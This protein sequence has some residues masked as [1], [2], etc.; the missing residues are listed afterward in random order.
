M[1]VFN[2]SAYLEE[3]IL[4][5]LA[6]TEKNWELIAV[7]D[8]SLD[9]SAVILN[10]FARQDSRVRVFQNSSKGIIPA[11]DLAFSKACGEYITR[12]DS[13]DIMPND[14]L[15]IMLEVSRDSARSVVTG[16]VQ[17]FSDQPVSDGYRRYENWLNRLVIEATFQTNIFR[18]CVVASPNWMVQRT[19]F[20][21]DFKFAELQYPEDYDMVFKWYESGYQFKGIP[22]VT[23][24]WREHESRLS[25]NSERYQQRSFFELKTHY[26]LK[27]K[28]SPDKKLQLIGAG[29]KGKLVSGILEK[30]GVVFD[31]FEFDVASK[32]TK[33]LKPV[34]ELKNELTILTNW[35]VDEF[36]QQEITSFLSE[37]GLE[38]GE[39]LWLF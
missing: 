17:Y 6:Q 29:K 24:K 39:N 31:W 33:R 22:E 21:Q 4:S 1:P 2:A 37:R 16:M 15:K 25:R 12:M 26:F 18:E 9:E 27:L 20:E 36:T 13:D 8:F 19:C 7:D 32:K 23:L 11:L 35:P 28:Y 30:N 14:R 38:F 5:I 34:I 3:T 10:D